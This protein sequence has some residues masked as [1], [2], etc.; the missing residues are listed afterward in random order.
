MVFV[1]GIDIPLVELIFV[2]TLILIL[3]FSILIYLVIS[4]SKLNKRLKEILGKENL[5]LRGLKSI[6]EKERTEI[7][8]L[9]RILYGVGSTRKTIR[10]AAK[11]KPKKKPKRKTV[12]VRR[13]VR[14]TATK[15][16]PVKRKP[17][18]RVVIKRHLR[19]KPAKKT[20]KRR[21]RYVQP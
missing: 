10:R 8:L 4:Q 13:V 16:R 12:T 5:E 18:K 14:K 1:F 7:G 20:K 3:L 2:L 15:R 9:R 11:R 19:K 17:T 21:Y 6:D